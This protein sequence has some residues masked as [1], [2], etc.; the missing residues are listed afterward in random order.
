M[1]PARAPRDRTTQIKRV[2]VGLLIA[3]LA[4]L[5]AKFIIGATTGSLA[6]LGDAVHSS[7]DA[8]NNVLALGVMW[9]AAREPDEEHPYGHTKFETLGALAIVIFLSVGGFELAKG[10]IVRLVQ[11]TIPL[12]ISGTQLAILGSTLVVNT[13][14]A[15]Y[16]TRRGHELHSDILLADA[17]H[18]RADVFITIGVIAGLVLTRAGFA[19]A[20]PLVALVVVVMIVWVAWGIVRRAVP[21]L[22][23]EH[24]LPANLIRETAEQVNGVRS[25]YQIRSRGAPHLR[26]AEVTIAVD[27]NATVEAGHR[28]ADAV[29]QRLREQLQLHEVAVHIEPC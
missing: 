17:A 20:D 5:G 26:F 25:A 13:A 27:G 15:I 9:I 18:T 23:D 2:L 28:I 10:S 1:S 8:V 16:E 7:V 14:V 3:N 24:A 6:V 12:T 11:G 22:V 19:F 21:V 4:V 29:E